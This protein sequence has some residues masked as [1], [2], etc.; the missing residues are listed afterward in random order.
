[1]TTQGDGNSNDRPTGGGSRREPPVIDGQAHVVV[2]PAGDADNVVEAAD[3]SA[4]DAP[5]APADDAV[6]AESDAP[7]K[8]RAGLV[9]VGALVV[10]GGA[11]GWLVAPG[12]RTADD[13]RAKILGMLPQGAQSAIDTLKAQI[14]PPSNAA[15]PAASAPVASQDSS[16]EKGAAEKPAPV[17]AASQPAA[18]PAPASSADA[19]QTSPAWSGALAPLTQKPADQKP[20]DNDKLAALETRV[21][22]LQT[23]L[24]ATQA[25]L[26]AAQAR[27]DAAAKADS[28][29]APAPAAQ[30]SDE[31][32]AR[33]ET[34]TQRLAALEA[35]LAAPKVEARATQSR[36]NGEA[37]SSDA[38]AARAV[39]AQS[40][41]QTLAAGAPLDSDLAA[42]RNLGV[43][44][45]KLAALAVYAKAGAP[46]A[47][48]FAAQWTS[49]RAKVIASDAAAPGGDW[50]D[51][52]FAKAKSLVKVEPLGAQSGA[53]AAA[54]YSRVDAAL[55][56][57]WRMTDN[58]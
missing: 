44:D 2:E 10:V 39:I 18:Q 9:A 57:G 21:E 27:L 12:E 25:K 8:G 48:Q 51:K 15:K 54:V 26:D 33:I 20:A 16:A 28:A 38:N 35:R 52:L 41:A 42:L 40:L 46:G 3:E 17:A 6:A 45:D 4:A 29:A 23:R 34:L 58:G 24:E 50:S 1:M 31:A 53:S 22:A 49:L 43:G 36:E 19:A 56:R 55:Q 13:P 11:F 37:A 47:K 30:S 14:A 7:R 5:R 32:N